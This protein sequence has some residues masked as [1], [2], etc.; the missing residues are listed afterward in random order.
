MVHVNTVSI[1]EDKHAGDTHQYIYFQRKTSLPATP[2][3]Y[4]QHKKQATVDHKKLFAHMIS[5]L[6]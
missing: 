1:R 2:L 6:Q 4:E 5:T 3:T